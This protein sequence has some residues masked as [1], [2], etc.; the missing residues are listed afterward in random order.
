MP[1][2]E[3]E[4][5]G[6]QSPRAAT[7]L[8]C[9][10]CGWSTPTAPFDAMHIPGPTRCTQVYNGPTFPPYAGHPTQKVSGPCN[11]PLVRQ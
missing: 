1:A 4:D 5:R 2:A 7:N 10:R 9:Q 3:S 11:G 6:S 8:V